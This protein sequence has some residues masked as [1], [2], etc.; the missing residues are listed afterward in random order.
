MKFPTG[1]IGVGE[2]AKKH[3]LTYHYVQ[4]GTVLDQIPFKLAPNGYNKMLLEFEALETPYIKRAL[5]KRSTQPIPPPAPSSVPP[6]Q[7]PPEREAPPVYARTITPGIPPAEKLFLLA[8]RQAEP[9]IA[10]AKELRR[11]GKCQAEAEILW[12]AIE[13]FGYDPK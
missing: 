7:P 12:L 6:P 8:R 5:A 11:E 9:Y 2:F 4:Q 13:C 10:R 1:F 3:G